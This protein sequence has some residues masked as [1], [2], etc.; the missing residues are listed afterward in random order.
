MVRGELYSPGWHF[1]AILAGSV[2]VCT[3]AA[4]VFF[5]PYQALISDLCRSE[6]NACRGFAVFVLMVSLGGINS[7]LL[8]AWDWFPGRCSLTRARWQVYIGE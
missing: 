4:Q 8:F 1:R 6:Q 5:N 2:V 7:S 3:F